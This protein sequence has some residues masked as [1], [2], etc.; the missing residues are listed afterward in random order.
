MASVSEVTYGLCGSGLDRK[1]AGVLAAL[2]VEGPGISCDIEKA[3]GLRQ[4]EVS[5]GAK[6]GVARGWISAMKRPVPRGRPRMEY[7]LAVPVEEILG[8]LEAGAGH[9]RKSVRKA[10]EHLQELAL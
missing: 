9:E 1:L 2:I 6:E 5:I 10:A 8:S 3:A 4:P 7:R